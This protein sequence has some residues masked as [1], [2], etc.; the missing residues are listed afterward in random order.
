MFDVVEK[1]STRRPSRICYAAV[2]FLCRRRI[3]CRRRML[4]IFCKNLDKITAYIAISSWA[5]VTGYVCELHD[6]PADFFLDIIN[7]DSTAIHAKG[8]SY[9]HLLNSLDQ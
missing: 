2:E 4:I 3:A 1:T 9:I 6:N 5:C 7:G 8:M